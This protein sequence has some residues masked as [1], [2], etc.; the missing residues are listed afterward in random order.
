MT[1]RKCFCRNVLICLRLCSHPSQPWLYRAFCSS[2]VQ[3][4]GCPWLIPRDQPGAQ[5]LLL[6]THHHPLFSAPASRP[7][8]WGYQLAPGFH[9][10]TGFES[11]NK[12]KL[13]LQNGKDIKKDMNC[14]H[15]CC[16]RQ[17]SFV[18]KTGA[19][20][21]EKKVGFKSLI[22]HLWCKILNMLL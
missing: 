4:P 6:S 7:N 20:V 14:S 15:T 9:W 16:R 10:F 22:C 17:Y 8:R 18:M 3:R 12:V 13:F 11:L 2:D 21:S 19:V 1:S 5:P